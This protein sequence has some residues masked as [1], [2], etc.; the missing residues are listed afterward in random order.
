M[1][2]ASGMPKDGIPENELLMFIANKLP[3]VLTEGRP[4]SSGLIVG[5]HANPS[6]LAPEPYHHRDAEPQRKQMEKQ[7]MNQ[8]ESRFLTNFSVALW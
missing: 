2:K 1:R 6:L 8:A 7:F 3:E 5:Y 4:A